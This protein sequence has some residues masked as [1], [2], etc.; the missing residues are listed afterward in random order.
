MCRTIGCCCVA[1]GRALQNGCATQRQLPRPMCACAVLGAGQCER[2]YT[3]PCPLAWAET[4]SGAWRTARISPDNG[5]A[6]RACC[7]GACQAPLVR[8]IRRLS[9]ACVRCSVGMICR[10]MLVRGGQARHVL[11][12][13]PCA[14]VAM[15]G[16]CVC[17]ARAVRR[18]LLVAATNKLSARGWLMCMPSHLR[19]VCSAQNPIVVCRGIA[20]SSACK[21]T[22]ACLACDL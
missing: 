20:G 16:V 17:A 14:C 3:Q 7:S 10:I 9:C 2:D 22:R 6:R 21:I 1:F 13:V 15:R 12:S 8:T 5:N 18:H 19:G 11:Q 4:G